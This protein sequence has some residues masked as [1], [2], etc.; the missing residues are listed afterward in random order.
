MDPA[1]PSWEFGLWFVAQGCL[2]SFLAVLGSIDHWYF[3]VASGTR[4][5]QAILKLRSQGAPG[6]GYFWWDS[7]KGLWWV[8]GEEIQ[9]CL[10]WTFFVEIPKSRWISRSRFSNKGSRWSS[11][12]HQ[13]P[14]KVYVSGSLD[15]LIELRFCCSCKFSQGHHRSYVW[16]SNNS[17]FG[18]CAP[19][20]QRSSSKFGRI[21]YPC[22]IFL[23]SMAIFHNLRHSAGWWFGTFFIFPYIGNNH[24]NWLIFFRGVQT[25]N[26]SVLWWVS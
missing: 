16:T 21:S 1:L 26:Q 19:D 2:S 24:P 23:G 4:V 11:D 10:G 17:S 9:K 13:V 3:P 8:T 18:A 22:I 5:P 25:T 14:E 6:P 20:W 12:Q 15:D 7:L